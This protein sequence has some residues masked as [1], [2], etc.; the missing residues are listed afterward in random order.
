MWEI[1][2][3]KKLDKFEYEC[4][5]NLQNF[6][7]KNHEQILK[8][9]QLLNKRD[10]D[11]LIQIREANDLTKRIVGNNVSFVINQNI[12]FTPY[13]IGGCLFCAFHKDP[14]KKTRNDLRLNLSDIRQETINAVERGVKEV[15]I[16]GG[17]DPNLT[18]DFYISILHT[19]REVDESLHI[20][21]F[22]PQEVAYM[23]NLS[24]KSI[25][26]VFQD[27]KDH[28]LDSFPGTAAEILVDSTRNVICPQKIK[29]TEWANIVITGHKVGLK[30]SST[31]MYGHIEAISDQ[32]EHLAILRHIQDKTGGFTEFVPLQY[33]PDNTD[34]Y[35]KYGARRGSTGLEDLALFSTARL[36]FKKKIPNIQASWIKMGPKAAQIALNCGVNDL[37]GTLFRE[38]ISK[39]AGARHGE[40]LSEDEFIRII[41]DAGKHPVQRDTLYNVVKEY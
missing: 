34:L 26:E 35:R 23:A 15:C 29:A 18:Y 41:K 14:Y 39:A 30:S 19:V 32:A 17:L 11:L 13:C 1:L 8:L 24:G 25:V 27:L 16:Q 21:A 38:N 12:N 2:I 20:H 3:R 36:Y 37:G 31:M 40:Y 7:E 5:L 6:R 22:S 4:H 28:G 9:E 33:I 10:N